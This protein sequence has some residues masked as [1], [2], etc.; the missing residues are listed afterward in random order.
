MC[1]RGVFLTF[2]INAFIAFMTCTLSKRFFDPCRSK[3]ANSNKLLC[4][5]CVQCITALILLFVYLITDIDTGQTT[6][7]H[8]KIKHECIDYGLYHSVCTIHFYKL[9][10][11]GSGTFLSFLIHCVLR[12]DNTKYTRKSCTKRSHV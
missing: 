11:N 12:Q 7:A 4:M 1:C 8:T 5:R 6:N 10:S 9:D 3:R 2:A